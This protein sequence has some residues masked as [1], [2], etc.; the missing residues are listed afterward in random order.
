MTRTLGYL[1]NQTDRVRCAVSQESEAL[2]FG[3][4]CGAWGLGSVQSGEALLR[5]RPV[6]RG[7]GALLPEMVSD[8][9]TG[10]MIASSRRA[11]EFRRHE[12]DVP[13]WRF[14]QWLCAVDGD[15]GALQ[16]IR[17]GLEL[18]LPDFFLRNVRGEGG[19]ERVAH[20]LFAQLHALGRLDDPDLD[21]ASLAACMR[22][23][24]ERVDALLDGPVPLCLMATN[25]RVLAALSR[26]VPLSWVR[27][28]GVRDV[29]ACAEAEFDA[30]RGRRLDAETLKHLRYVMIA[31]GDVVE[32]FRPVSPDGVPLVAVDRGLDVDVTT[33]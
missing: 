8:L 1:A 10:A 22:E 13:P 5:R 19:D 3:V 29:A 15:L 31:A 28:H 9:R 33:E 6:D 23:S 11:D 32:G 12:E 27:R 17:E 2:A 21:R 30:R 4:G 18:A 25:G 26:A 14:R 16:S 24:F 20:V 7:H